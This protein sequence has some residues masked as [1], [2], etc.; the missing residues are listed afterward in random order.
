MVAAG[1]DVAILV[2]VLPF[3]VFPVIT[4]LAPDLVVFVVFCFVSPPPTPEMLNVGA[5]FAAEPFSTDFFG[6]FVG[7]DLV[8]GGEPNIEKVGVR[9]SVS[10]D[11][12]GAETGFETDEEAAR[13]SG[14]F[15]VDG[16]AGFFSCG[17]ELVAAGGGPNIENVADFV[18]VDNEADEF[19]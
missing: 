5:F 8:L 17:P 7:A 19:V 13:N 12:G 15:D 4:C 1:W 6:A 14:C 10:E 16:E 2:G 3:V 18:N 11:A 9:F